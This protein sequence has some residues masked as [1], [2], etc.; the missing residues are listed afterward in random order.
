VALVKEPHPSIRTTKLQG[1]KDVARLAREVIRDDS[2]T[3]QFLTFALDTQNRA[4]AVN[5]TTTGLLNSSLIHPREVFTFAICANAASV[6][7][8]H[9]H[10]S[11]DP[12]P[13]PEDLEVTWQIA[14][15]GSLVGI[16]VRD[17]IIIGTGEQTKPVW[18]LSLLE[19]GLIPNDRK[20]PKVAT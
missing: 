17:H 8:C 15:A 1:P 19:R 16:P 4:V 7:L 18:F 14:E 2:P 5:V 12:S 13:S 3:E 9:N 20:G 10:P 11:G 6:I